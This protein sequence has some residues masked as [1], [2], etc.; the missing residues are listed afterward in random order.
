[1]TYETMT[2]LSSMWGL[3]YFG[4]LFAGVLIYALNPK[5]KKKFEHA[6]HIPLKEGDIDD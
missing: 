5:S 2:D 3:I 6:A 4:I 1:M